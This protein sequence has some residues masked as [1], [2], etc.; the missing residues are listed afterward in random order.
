MVAMTLLLV[1]GLNWGLYA[2]DYNLVNMLLGSWPVVE[3][4]VYV[5][6]GLSAVWMLVKH[7]GCCMKKS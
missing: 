4:I 5:A 3:Q 7:F 2:F 6:V 1:G